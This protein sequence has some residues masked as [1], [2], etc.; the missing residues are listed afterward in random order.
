LLFIYIFANKD[1]LLKYKNAPFILSDRIVK[2]TPSEDG[3]KFQ[4]GGEIVR[5]ELITT[6]SL[7]K[8]FRQRNASVVHR[9]RP[10]FSVYQ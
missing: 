7:K 2:K 9:Y 1:A 3:A 8:K 6:L 5:E 4:T 10:Y